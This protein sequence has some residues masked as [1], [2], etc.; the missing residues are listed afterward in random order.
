MAKKKKFDLDAYRKKLKVFVNSLRKAYI[1]KITNKING[2]AYIGLTTRNP[3]KRFK[4][5]CD[6]RLTKGRSLIKD[7]INKYGKNNFE[8]KIILKTNVNDM[9]MEEA[10][11]IREFDT[12]APNGYNCVVFDKTPEITI[13][14][15]ELMSKS[16]QGIEPW[17]KGLKGKQKAW[18]KGKP[19]SKASKAI[20][21]INNNTGEVL[22]YASSMEAV[23]DKGFN[24]G[25]ITQCCKGKLNQHKGYVFK[26]L[27][28]YRREQGG[29]NV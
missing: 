6:G 22:K 29:S 26:Y 13:S 27:E 18:N 17:N 24:S 28:E 2:K 8:F 14:T 23:R 15:R 11:M 3:S 5:H 21:A 20:V 19:N 9:K 7:A 4:E 1:Y 16:K 12:L 25:H 10:Y